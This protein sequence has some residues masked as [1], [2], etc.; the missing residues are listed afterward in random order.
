MY[1]DIIQVDKLMALVGERFPNVDQKKL[2]FKLNQ[3]CRDKTRSLRKNIRPID[4][5]PTDAGS[6]SISY[7][8]HLF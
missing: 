2:I 8:H 4:N 1:C 5:G 3:K 6:L 7:L